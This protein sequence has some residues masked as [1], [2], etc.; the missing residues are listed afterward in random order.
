MI[1]FFKPASS[2]FPRESS[3]ENAFFIA[4]PNK[5]IWVGI[6][7]FMVFFID[8]VWNADEGYAWIITRITVSLGA[9]TIV[10]VAFGSTDKRYDF[11]KYDPWICRVDDEEELW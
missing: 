2:R 10:L 8:E 5:S 4:F 6:L 3:L 11:N 7:V 1:T 9:A